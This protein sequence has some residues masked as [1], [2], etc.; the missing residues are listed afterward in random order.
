MKGCIWLTGCLI[1]QMLLNLR[2][3]ADD[4]I[5]TDDT[6]N[7]ERPSENKNASQL[8]ATREKLVDDAIN[9][10]RRT[11]DNLVWLT[12]MWR[13]KDHRSYSH[14]QSSMLSET[15]NPVGYFGSA[16]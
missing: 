8:N 10:V 5:D 9:G 4:N 11:D 3:V 15:R 1:I 14:P 13:N 6:I 16:P 12:D 2:E 7:A